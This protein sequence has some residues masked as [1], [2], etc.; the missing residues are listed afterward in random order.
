MTTLTASDIAKHLQRPGEPLTAAVDRFRNWT[1]TGIIKSAGERNPGTGHHKQYSGAALAQAIL[2]QAL[3]D[4]LGSSAISLGPLISEMAARAVAIASATTG[5]ELLILT[6]SHE[7]GEFTVS[8]ANL[9]DLK[10][11]VSNAERNIHII[12]NAR[13]I[14]ERQRIA[15]DWREYVIETM[16]DAHPELKRVLTKGTTVGIFGEG[17]ER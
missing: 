9:D 15:Y 5:P 1:K 4:A 8:D 6:R 13:K 10:D 11:F 16:L 2:L 3:T 7:R 17:S 12:I 14:F